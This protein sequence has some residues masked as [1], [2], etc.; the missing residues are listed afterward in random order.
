MWVIL[1]SWTLKLLKAH[2]GDL[3]QCHGHGMR[4]ASKVS[5]RH[6]VVEALEKTPERHLGRILHC[7]DGWRCHVLPYEDVHT[8]LMNHRITWKDLIITQDQ[9]PQ[10]VSCI[11]LRIYFFPCN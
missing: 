3:E 4:G 1:T 10:K 9:T 7:K 6:I 5:F 11:T 2:G 8:R